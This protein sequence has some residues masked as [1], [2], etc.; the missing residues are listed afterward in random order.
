MLSAVSFCFMADHA[1]LGGS[2]PGYLAPATRALLSPISAVA[3]KDLALQLA[4]L[5]AV[6]IDDTDGANACGSAR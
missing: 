3:K 4:D 6:V 1:Q 5:D 2:T